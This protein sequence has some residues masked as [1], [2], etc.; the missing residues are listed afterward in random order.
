MRAVL[1][2]I[3][4]SSVGFRRHQKTG[5]ERSRAAVMAVALCSF[6]LGATSAVG[7]SR[8][9]DVR[10]IV[11]RQSESFMQGQNKGFDDERGALTSDVSARQVR[12]E[13]SGRVLL[14]VP[15][16]RLVSL[17][18]EESK[19]PVRFFGRVGWFLTIHYV[20]DAGEPAFA[21]LRLS[22]DSAAGLLRTL[23]SDTG[24]PVD[25]TP[26]RT[27][28]LGLPLHLTPGTPVYV[29][30]S[31]GRRIKGKLAGLSRSAIDL[32]KAGRFDAASVRRID[33]IDS[34]WDGAIDGAAI[35]GLP[36]FLVL[37]DRNYCDDCSSL[38]STVG[39]WAI[40]AV[41]GALL[42]R[43]VNRLAY[44]APDPRASP[45]VVWTPVFDDKRKG[46]HLSVRF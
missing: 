38:P 35:L 30:D 12:F 45:R 24:L 2:T 17:H 3:G 16:D 42:D 21:L 6:L 23:E 10:L 26:P 5:G 43:R 37:W 1:P 34:V 39:G 20:R 33:E 19:Y 14:A 25:R 41:V 9:D 44:R 40:G 11:D 4:F 18:Y 8:F 15:F 31:T 28:F 7:Q 46:L 29:T 32:G 13:T 27:S 36:I 22:R